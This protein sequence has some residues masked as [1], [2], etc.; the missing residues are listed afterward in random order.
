MKIIK[1]TQKPVSVIVSKDRHRGFFIAV[2]D[3]GQVA[4]RVTI[5]STWVA[6]DQRYG[7]RYLMRVVET[8]YNDDYDLK[9]ILGLVRDNPDQ[10]FDARSLEYYCCEKAW[11]R[12]EGEFVEDGFR[13]AFD[14][15]TVLQTFLSPTTESDDVV[16]AS[17]D[18]EH[19][20]VIGNLRS[21]SM[22]L[23]PIVTLED[24]FLGHRTFI[25]GAS[26]FGK[27]TLVRDIARHWLEHTEHGK[28][29]DDLKGE[30][31]AD[32][33]NEAGQT[34]Y[35]L[36]HHP[37][38]SQNL[39]FL[40]SRPR[41]F[42]GSELRRQIGGIIPLSFRIDD[43]PTDSLGDISTHLTPA[44]RQ[45]L[46]RYQ[47]RSGLFSSLL[48]ETDDGDLDTS[49]WH[50]QFQGWI[51]ATKTARTRIKADN[52]T[53]DLA[54]FDRSSYVP[55]YGVH[56]Q[57]KRLQSRPYIT[58][59]GESCLPRLRELLRQ[60]ATIILDKSG[61]TDGDRSIISTV[62]ANELYKH[63]ERYSSGNRMEQKQVIP[64]IYIVEEAH[65]LLSRERV[66]E[67]SVFVD[68]AK[69]GRSFQIGLVAV[70]QR[71]SSVDSNILSQFDN[72]IT[73]RLT[74]ELDVKDLVRAK[75]EFA[76]YEGDIRTM[77]RGAA[78]TA[79]GEP[80]KVQSI[81]AFDWTPERAK[82]LLS[83]EQDRLLGDLVKA[84]RGH[85]KDH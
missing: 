34:V 45:F 50:K 55:I 57:L 80:T 82:T 36:C 9:Q 71:P 62:I 60:G 74:S 14:Q 65:L 12:L 54:D 10:P 19:G 25:T 40:T 61:L 26:G 51:I 44:Q 73:F 28:I 35:G 75:S 48:R 13:E 6:H 63:N 47:H 27:S 8:G 38:A 59:D 7:R 16:I 31:V 81:Q 15:P 30:Y 49:D 17:P 58:T 24:R 22:I 20:F 67:G 69:T 3:S 77:H 56:R 52:Y 39:Y 2:F 32:I 43:I 42:E 41:R 53:T 18:V 78:V 29:I 64:F 4:P 83:D 5:G 33:Q 21:G 68:F 79:F 76:G 37:K 23:E 11:L 84:D 1:K 70:T 72:F 85:S 46:D 66:S